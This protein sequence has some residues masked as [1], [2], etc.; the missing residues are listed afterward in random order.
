MIVPTR[1]GLGVSLSE[2]ARE[3]TRERAEFGK[4]P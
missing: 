3:W 1:P 4:R 2:K